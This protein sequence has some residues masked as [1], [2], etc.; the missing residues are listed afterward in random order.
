MALRPTSPPSSP[1]PLAP[2]PNAAADAKSEAQQDVFLREV[3][4]ALREDQLLDVWRNH[5]RT[6]AV[7]LGLALIGL[8]AWLWYGEREQSTAGKAGESLIVALDQVEAGRLDAGARALAPLGAD[9][10][11]GARVAAQL[12]RAGIALE[13]GRKAEAARIYAAVAADD[14]TPGPYRDLATIREVAVTFDTLPPERVIARL[15]PLA[16]P[17]NA[18]F[19]SAGE[20]VG[21]A[22]LKQG[23]GELAGPLFAA[24]AKDRNVPESLRART[25]QLAGLLGVDAVEDP[26]RAASQSPVSAPGTGPALA[27]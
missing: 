23:R 15:K 14:A 22:Y 21:A 2:R 8:A 26:E 13:Q 1:N 16:V 27:P 19:G 6:I 18:F 24:I 5:G 9:G 12:M 20:L 17:G 25:R 11:D 3:D 4:D 10:P 7:V